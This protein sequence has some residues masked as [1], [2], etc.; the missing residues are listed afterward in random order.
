VD[1]ANQKKTLREKTI[2]EAAVAVTGVGAERDPSRL[3]AGT[4]ASEN[5]KLTYEA[6]D[7][8]ERRRGSVGA[9][10]ANVALNARDLQFAGRATPQWIKSARGGY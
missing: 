10:G 5:N 7:Q 2:M 6:L 1:L 3:L 9:H 4:K 8:A